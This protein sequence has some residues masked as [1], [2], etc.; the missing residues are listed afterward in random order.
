MIMRISV[1]C[2]IGGGDQ[3]DPLGLEEALDLSGELLLS[4]G[5]EVLDGLERDDD[6]KDDAGRAIGWRR[7]ILGGSGGCPGHTQ[8]GVLDRLLGT[9]DAVDE[10]GVG[11]KEG[12]AVAFSGGDIE[13]RLSSDERCGVVISVPMLVGDEAV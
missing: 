1:D 3:E 6:V 4:L 12:T 13:D 2:P 8:L 7:P 5:V 11:G 10:S 9:I